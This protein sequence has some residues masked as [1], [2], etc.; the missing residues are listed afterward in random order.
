VSFAQEAAIAGGNG[1]GE[2]AAV[3]EAQ[4]QRPSDQ[5]HVRDL[6]VR[7]PFEPMQAGYRHAG[8]DEHPLIAADRIAHLSQNGTVFL[9]FTDAGRL[10]DELEG[11]VLHF[12]ILPTTGGADTHA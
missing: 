10:F 12:V 3:L 5:R 7:G 11:G 4:Q 1:D 6:E 2:R 9:E 8:A